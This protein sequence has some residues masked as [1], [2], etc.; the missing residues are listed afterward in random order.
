MEQLLTIT[1]NQVLVSSRQVAEH[2]EKEHQHVTQAIENLISE[3]SLVKN[4]FHESQYNTE[5]GRSYKE[6]LMNRDGF[7]LLVMGFTGKKALQWKL[8]YIEAFNQLEKIVQEKRTAEWVQA[9][10]QGKLT[11]QSE[12]DVTSS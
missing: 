4:Y 3:N 8:K 2:F 10:K 9:R 6:Y 1:R 12:T 5:R 7:S 11:R